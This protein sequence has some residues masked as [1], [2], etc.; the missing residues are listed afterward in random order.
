VNSGFYP[1]TAKKSPATAVVGLFD[2]HYHMVTLE[3]GFPPTANTYYR[4]VRMGKLCR[5]ILSNRG[6]TYKEEV[7]RAVTEI[8][9]CN[10][11]RY[12]CLP[13]HASDRLSV[14]IKL[15]APTRRKYDIDNRIKP[16]LDA[17]AFACVFPDD[18]AV[19]EIT[20]KRKEIIKGGKVIVKLEKIK[21]QENEN[22]TSVD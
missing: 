12:E 13:F 19:D 17:L 6:R 22:K 4:T 2:Y 8:Q 3:L 11:T 15:Y 5:V 18:E 10:D 21:E 20:V 7:A 14:D 1:F 16:L 9:N